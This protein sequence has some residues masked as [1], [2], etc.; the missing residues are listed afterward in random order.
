MARHY[1]RYELEAMK[2]AVDSAFAG[3]GDLAAL[4]MPAGDG[5]VIR[6]PGARDSAG[7]SETA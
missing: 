2:K 5:G 7:A 1:S 4:A 3:L 6:F